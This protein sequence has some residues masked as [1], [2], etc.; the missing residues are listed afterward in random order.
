MDPKIFRV[1]SIGPSGIKTNW[2]NL[3]DSSRKSKPI[4]MVIPPDF[5]G[6]GGTYSPED[7][8][9]L[10]LVNCF[11]ATFKYMAEKS[12][13]EFSE[14]RGEGALYVEKGNEKSLWM[15]RAELEFTIVEPKQ[16]E[17]ILNLLDKTK[18]NCMIINSVKTDVKFTFNIID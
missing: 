3:L 8:Y 14:I 11:L 6:P 5:G 4:D 12:K 15:N 13:L 1:N 16:K 10:S 17:R 2:I 7:L 18:N 9:L